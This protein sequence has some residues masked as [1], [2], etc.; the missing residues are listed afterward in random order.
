MILNSNNVTEDQMK[1]FEERMKKSLIESEVNDVI[2]AEKLRAEY[3][4]RTGR[5][6]MKP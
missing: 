6:E 4:R 3:L 2:D 5:K 1:A